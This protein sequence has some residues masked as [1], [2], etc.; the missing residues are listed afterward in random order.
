MGGRLGRSLHMA[1]FAGADPAARTFSRRSQRR[2]HPPTDGPLDDVEIDA[3]VLA[4]CA[5][6]AG[7]ETR[8]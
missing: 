1:G 8:L 5:R 3:G 4:R 6:D 7:L 2:G